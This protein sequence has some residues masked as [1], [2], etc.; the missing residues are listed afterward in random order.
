MRAVRV[1]P[2]IAA[3]ASL[4]ADRSR[5]AILQALLEGAALAAGDL[6]RRAGVSP[7]T[8]SSHLA[9]LQA[10]GLVACESS[11]RLRCYR[12]ASPDVVQ[13]LEVLAQLAPAAPALTEPAVVSARELRL[14][15]TCYDHLAGWLGCA[16]TDRLVAAG[17]L[18]RRGDLFT[19]TRG[20]RALMSDLGIEV[21]RLERGRR[22]LARACV[23]WSER[24]PHLAG[25]L[26]AAFTTELLARGWLAR[27]RA[28]RAVRVTGR[29]RAALAE[30]LGVDAP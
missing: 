7:S 6:A 18:R 22:P 10:G 3:I 30:R 23:D 25:A 27:V 1:D 15:R 4:V 19:I 16:V 28:S 5:A 17:H 11:G 24:R 29:G 14:A 8:A 2:D 20:G 12:L 9:R 13:L 26:G 21:D